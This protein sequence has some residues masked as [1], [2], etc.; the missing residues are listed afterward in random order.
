MTSAIYAALLCFNLA[1]GAF[2][3][4]WMQGKRNVTKPQKGGS[5]ES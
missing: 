3:F 2:L 4:G 5:R 1:A